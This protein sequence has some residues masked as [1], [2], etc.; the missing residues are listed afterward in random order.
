MLLKLLNGMYDLNRQFML[1]TLKCKSW[2]MSLEK[3]YVLQPS[4]IPTLVLAF[5]SVGLSGLISG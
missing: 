1:Y 3:N 5:I 4:E 2:I